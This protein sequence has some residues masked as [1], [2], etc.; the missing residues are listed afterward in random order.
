M[1]YFKIE[2]RAAF[3]FCIFLSCIMW[4]INA[5]S[6]KYTVQ[7]P[8]A[9]QYL[10]LPD[11]KVSI[12]PLPSS[13]Q[14]T[15]VAF[16]MDIL[17]QFNIR[18]PI[19]TIDCE[20]YKNKQRVLNTNSLIRQ[21]EEKNYG[22]RITD[23]DPDSIH[24][25]FDKKKTKKVALRVDY[26]ISAAPHFKLKEVKAQNPDSI[27][28]SGPVAYI[29]TLKQWPTQKI[30]MRDVNQPSV[31]DI[32]LM[33]PDN[34]SVTL[35]HK[36]TTYQIEVSEFT[37]KQLELP[38]QPIHLPSGVRVFLYPNV[39]TLHFQVLTDNFDDIKTEDFKV[40]AD[41]SNM[42]STSNANSVVALKLAELPS[43]IKSPEIQPKT[44]EFIIIQ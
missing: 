3:I 15:V 25:V 4:L 39:V 5:L 13:L 22:L 20:Q 31:G 2:D 24:F 1:K 19:L 44:A 29:D 36:K 16:G 40:V 14:L 23:I 35:S 9:V 26:D 32:N 17:K 38:I 11:D 33:I 6:E 10:N 8:I 34:N 18:N 42:D 28:V 27:E 41:F 12:Y 30:M 37:E 21:I 7:M 43:N